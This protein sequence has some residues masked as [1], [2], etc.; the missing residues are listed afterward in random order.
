MSI[1]FATLAVVLA[2]G[3]LGVLDYLWLRYI[4]EQFSDLS[5]ARAIVA[6]RERRGGYDFRSVTWSEVGVVPRSRGSLRWK[7]VNIVA[8][9]VTSPILDLIMFIIGQIAQV[10]LLAIIFDLVVSP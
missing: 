1:I 3:P 7:Y 4:R 10:F 5:V 9:D 8:D 6:E 2:A